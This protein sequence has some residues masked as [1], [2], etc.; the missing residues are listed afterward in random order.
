MTTC[1][2]HTVIHYCAIYSSY[3][4]L[5]LLVSHIEDREKDEKIGQ[6]EKSGILKTR[7]LDATSTEGETALHYAI[8]AK[9][10]IMCRILMNYSCNMLIR[11]NKGQTGAILCRTLGYID[12]ADW[13]DKKVYITNTKLETYN[14]TQLEKSWRYSHM[15]LKECL[16]QFSKL[17]LSLF[18][19]TSMVN[20][21]GGSGTGGG[22]VGGG[23]C[24]PDPT[25]TTP[26]IDMLL[27]KYDTPIGVPSKVSLIS[28][29]KLQYF[30]NKH[31][32]IINGH[33]SDG[34]NE[35]Y[36]TS[37]ELYLH[38][39]SQTT[40]TTN[41]NS[42]NN[43][44][45]DNDIQSAKSN[46]SSNTNTYISKKSVQVS[47]Q[48]PALNP[49]NLSSGTPQ[50]S[51]IFS[52]VNWLTIKEIK[53]IIELYK[54]LYIMID[55][56][57]HSMIPYNIDIPTHPLSL[58][59]LIC[60]T[61]LNCPKALKL[62][63]THSGAGAAAGGGTSRVVHQANGSGTTPL[64]VA[65]QLHNMDV[66]IDIL[67]QY[68][69]NT[70]TTTATTSNNNTNSSTTT[71]STNSTN[72]GSDIH[73]VDTEGYSALA[74][75]NSIP[76]PVI[77]H[78][79][80]LSVIYDE[81]YT[82]SNSNTTTNNNTDNSRSAII[83]PTQV[84]K[85][86][87]SSDNTTYNTLVHTYQQQRQQQQQRSKDYIANSF[88]PSSR[89]G[90]PYGPSDTTTPST[91]TRPNFNLTPS[92]ATITTNTCK[93]RT[94]ELLES[95]GLTNI[96]TSTQLSKELQS[97][98]WRL[99][100]KSHYQLQQLE[101]QNTLKTL[102]LQQQLI[103]DKARKN[104][105]R[106]PVCTL[107]VPCSHYFN[108]KAL[109]AYL[110]SKEDA[111]LIVL[112]R[113]I[114]CICLLAYVLQYILMYFC[115][116]M[117]TILCTYSDS[118]ASATSSSLTD[119]SAPNL[120][121]A[122]SSSLAKSS[123][124]STH[125]T[126]LPPANDILVL[127]R[128]DDRHTDRSD[129]WLEQ[130]IA[131]K[132]L[133]LK[134]LRQ[135]AE[136][137]HRPKLL[138]KLPPSNLLPPPS[139]ETYDTTTHSTP[140]LLTDTNTTAPADKLIP[141]NSD[142]PLSPSSA[143]RLN[144]SHIRM[145][146]WEEVN[147]EVD[148]SPREISNSGLAPAVSQLYKTGDVYNS[149]GTTSTQAHNNR[150]HSVLGYNEIGVGEGSDVLSHYD[151]TIEYESSVEE[152][153]PSTIQQPLSS[154]HR[155]M[156]IK[157]SF[158]S[159]LKSLPSILSIASDSSASSTTTAISV[160]QKKVKRSISFAIPHNS[161]PSTDL[162]NTRD[163]TAAA[164]LE[165]KKTSK[166]SDI[167]LVDV[168]LLLPTKAKITQMND[169]LILNTPTTTTFTMTSITTPLSDTASRTPSKGHNYD[170]PEDNPVPLSDRK[171][172]YLSRMNGTVRTLR[173]S[174]KTFANGA[175]LNATANLSNPSLSVVTVPILLLQGHLTTAGVQ[176]DLTS[177]TIEGAYIDHAMFTRQ[178]YSHIRG[179]K[180]IS[181]NYDPSSSLASVDLKHKAALSYSIPLV[182]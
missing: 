159:S 77:Y 83:T 123:T 157:S 145:L 95:K 164:A 11:N 172:F 6:G 167:Q 151:S 130:Y 36:Q 146:P 37:Y 150:S 153:L 114:F 64:M 119:L 28:N 105:L 147:E 111:T 53:I 67:T 62:I 161:D 176:S 124:R 33:N 5:K 52:Y 131:P 34:S 76:E 128:L 29:I 27:G 41:N 99:D 7:F 180:A 32:L 39:L 13:L 149:S 109:E 101:I 56:I 97:L 59:P 65:A 75:A 104:R 70:N 61:V 26:T 86:A 113:Y 18:S 72:T 94:K 85:A 102:E 15:K 88:S 181:H 178:I 46:T 120:P 129:K 166:P 174:Q 20:N 71:N 179:E 23:G 89:T 138:P 162:N 24:T 58:T 170:G 79:E 168:K 106:C 45:T 19:I 80:M 93:L 143:P 68:K 110:Q 156:P 12:I 118:G 14:D 121:S 3:D 91:S 98:T 57:K 47:G 35:I 165:S 141:H 10:P 49:K 142:P 48:N 107:I 40:T 81:H 117:Y 96:Q 160:P 115:L 63:C 158:R 69:S 154:Q 44:Y 4:E 122:P 125:E 136:R 50:I 144:S 82:D 116:T 42:N 100:N 127:T 155:L 54:L 25:F 74:Y 132:A 163:S 139:H 22:G 103:D 21:G 73:A 78:R 108:V 133:T 137:K 51:T 16:L 43:I 92:T 66:L 17:Y 175:N 135:Q 31:H 148:D 9:D 173:P 38:Y 30:I 87:L 1:S 171:L 126:K 84:L 2:H 55:T 8:R 152:S 90:T 134:G 177:P 182:R 112:N 169:I 60:A 140:L